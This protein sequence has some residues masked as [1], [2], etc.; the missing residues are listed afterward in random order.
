VAIQDEI[1][2]L[3]EI[4]RN[5]LAS[6][7]PCVCGR[8]LKFLPHIGD[9]LEYDTSEFQC[10]ICSKNGDGEVYHCDTCEF[11]AHRD[12]AEIKEKVNVFFH[13]DPLHLLVQNY[14]DN[15][16][17]VICDFCEE[18]LQGSEWVY[19]CKQC[20]FN[21]HA[22]CTKHP[23]KVNRFE[24]HLHPLTLVQPPL[25]KTASCKCCNGHFKGYRYTCTQKRCSYDLHPFCIIL[26]R[27]PPCIFDGL[28]RLDLHRHNPRGFDC[29]RCGTPGL[30]W[31]YHC[32]HCGGDVHVGCVN[33]MEEEEENWNGAYEKFMLEYESKANHEKMDMIGKLL[34]IMLLCSSLETSSSSSSRPPPGICQ[35]CDGHFTECFK[36]SVTCLKCF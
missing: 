26:P 34:D 23:W 5:D 11:D 10:N 7:I 27:S 6:T 4:E 36:L 13:A 12:C 19:N 15:N 32:D 1:Y 29:G 20:N 25:R 24:V 2:D 22:L 9:I 18:S 35:Y 33:D 14:Y 28:H 8:S 21:V 17:D 3:N 31:F 16:P 30:P